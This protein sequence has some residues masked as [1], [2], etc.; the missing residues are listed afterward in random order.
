MKKTLTWCLPALVLLVSAAALQAQKTG[1]T[2]QA[3]ADLERQWLQAQ[4]TSNPDL[5]AQL[6]ADDLVSTSTEGKVTGKAETL[7]DIKSEKW[8]SPAYTDLKV[9]VYGNTAIAYG[10]FKGKG[11][12]ASG[13]PLDED[14]RWTD[15][16]VKMPNGKWQCVA[17]QATPVKM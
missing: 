2:E 9:H 12:D 7:A 13:K 17:S 10:G 15:T 16:W 5:L 3:V 6:L 4:K 11:T 14:F 8:T 1:D